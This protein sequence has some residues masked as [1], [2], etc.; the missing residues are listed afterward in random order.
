MRQKVGHISLLIALA[1]T[2]F[3]SL[4]STVT[5]DHD[6][7]T[8]SWTDGTESWQYTLASQD[9]TWNN[10]T[11]VWGYTQSSKTFAQNGGAR[12][13]KYE[14]DYDVWVGSTA[15]TYNL[16]LAT[17]VAQVWRYNS[18]NRT[19][20][21]VTRSTDDG[22]SFSTVPDLSW[23]YNTGT[24]RW[25]Y[26]RT[27]VDGTPHVPTAEQ[28]EFT[29]T[30]LLWKRKAPDENVSWLYNRV[31]GSWFHNE[32]EEE[33]TFRERTNEHDFWQITGETPVGVVGAPWDR[34]QWQYDFVGGLWQSEEVKDDPFEVGLVTQ[35]AYD[36]AAYEWGT[37]LDE[38]GVPDVEGVA[39]Q[40]PLPLL[41]TPFAHFKRLVDETILDLLENGHT[42][43]SDD[44][45]GDGLIDVANDA[46]ITN[47]VFKLNQIT[48]LSFV[49]TVKL[50]GDLE[51]EVVQDASLTLGD[52][53]PTG[54]VV[55]TPA[56]DATHAQLIFNVA[57]HK[58][59]TVNVLN[60]VSFLATDGV[61]LYL[62]FRGRGTTVFRLP[63]GKTVSFSAT[64]PD[65]GTKGVYLQVL[66]EQ[67]EADYTGRK[68]QL[69]FAPWSYAQESGDE[70]VNTNTS[71]ASQ[72]I[73]G[74]HCSL[75]FVSQNAAGVNEES[76]PGYGAVAFDVAH[77]GVG[78]TVFELSRGAS[79]G[80]HLD[81][82]INV[83]GVLITGS[84]SGSAVVASDFR[85]NV[86][87]RKLAG[88]RAVLRITDE[89]AL[90]SIVP[91]ITAPTTE[92]AAAWVARDASLRRGL[93]VLNKNQSY[94]RLAAN[95]EAA[96]TLE[97]S[98]WAQH[99]KRYHPGFILGTNGQID[100]WHNL[101]LD[102]VAASS[103]QA[104]A[105]T[106][107]GGAGKTT[108]D[109]KLRN[110]SALITDRLGSYSASAD[111]SWDMAYAG[112]AEPLITLRGSA[113]LFTRCGASA[114][115]GALVQAIEE[116]SESGPDK[117]DAT[118]GYGLYNGVYAPV[119]AT[120]GTRSV[121]ESLALDA[122]GNPI[123]SD[124]GGVRCLDGEHALI[125]EGQLTIRSVLGRFGFA[126]NGYINVPSLRL[127]HT[128][129]EVS[130][131]DAIPTEAS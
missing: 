10:G 80:D 60:D 32:L 83:Y 111:G 95:L 120:D 119:L 103:N 8:V 109:V 76:L 130:G 112:T 107:L 124:D 17:S 46:Y 89:T 78:R 98:S 14:A 122:A 101:F 74:R 100:I 66:M 61:P 118:I 117:L 42:W 33:W 20:H 114:S 75:Q 49:D 110:P 50:E 52:G 70:A 38:D 59:L 15:G 57:A 27:P 71:L 40:L 44:G 34:V 29:S 82:G 5:I 131:V 31:D 96:D 62:S 77:A 47:G 36:T 81:A 92:Q 13:W 105:A 7:G 116:V 23:S 51:L 126:P 54:D 11:N 41:P 21:L 106:Y 19:W 127:D 35:Y 79:A 4:H 86:L 56:D 68:S 88:I 87:P 129:T 67:L 102:Y 108:A 91:D 12:P 123:L 1:L 63:S 24:A 43:G 28:W 121:H 6:A 90:A 99:N 2:S 125:V 39:R 65:T 115:T 84:G 72:I 113:G 9:W 53:S 85:T 37:D 16:S 97:N 26:A 69:C 3:L 73:L 104:V 25:V 58:T 48:K 45:T 55:I 30:S 64:N 22:L 93:V 18:D 94:P 128:G